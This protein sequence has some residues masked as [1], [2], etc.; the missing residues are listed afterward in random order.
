MIRAD[1]FPG[2]LQAFFAERLIRQQQMSGHTIASYRDTFRLLFEFASVR[3]KKLPSMLNFED[4]EAPFIIAF[5]DHLEKA[6]GNSAQSR[7]VRLAAI[8]SFFRFAALNEPRCSATIQRVLAI[9][10]K[11]HAR[12]LVAFLTRPEIE[13]LLS[14]PDKNTWIG[15]RDRMLL[16]IA[17]QTGLRVS[18]LVGLRCED[19]VLG[20]GAHVHCNGKGRKERRTPLTKEAAAVL[21][22][23]LRE[24]NGPPAAALFPNVRGGF[25]NR[26]SVAHLLRKYIVSAARDCPSLRLKRV[27]PHVLRHSFAMRLLEQGVDRVVIALLLGHESL[28]STDVYLHGNIEMKEKAIARAAPLNAR[29]GRYRPADDLLVFLK[30]L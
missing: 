20:A 28:S 5:L 30:G 22:A 8:R 21:A 4:L 1:G 27:S 29:P 12:K 26:D 24:R 16:L 19:A 2:L 17:A 6:R 13:A 18:E 23:W 14:A 11:R 9:P 10:N 15:R 3:L 25:L 7:N